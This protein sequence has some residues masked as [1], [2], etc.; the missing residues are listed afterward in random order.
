MFQKFKLVIGDYYS[1]LH[2]K[3]LY[4]GDN[5]TKYLEAILFH[6]ESYRLF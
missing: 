5:F 4:S 1:R 2:E 6:L 3:V